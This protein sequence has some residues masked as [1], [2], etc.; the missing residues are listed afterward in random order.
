MSEFTLNICCMGAGYVGGPTMAVIALK[1]PQVRMCS[2]DVSTLLQLQFRFVVYDL[3][4]MTHLNDLFL[5]FINGSVNQKRN[6]SLIIQ[7]L[8]NN[9]NHYDRSECA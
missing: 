6:N 5:K 7:L 1:C 8:N 4:A 9:N 3:I 2:C